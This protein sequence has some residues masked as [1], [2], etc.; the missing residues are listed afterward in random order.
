MTQSGRASLMAFLATAAA[1]AAASVLPV[2]RDTPAILVLPVVV[3]I[4]LSLPAQAGL[5]GI[6]TSVLGLAVFQPA[7]S[8]PI[9]ALR[10]GSFF[11]LGGAI[12][13]LK[14][15]RARALEATAQYRL[16]FELNPLPMW[17][18]DEETLAFQA[19]NHAAI[20]KYGYSRAEFERL[21]LR[22][23]RVE[24][25]IAAVER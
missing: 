13:A 7:A 2:V 14:Y 8:V 15:G 12:V 10:A 20:E 17:V 25:D 21:T 23:I 5:I 11:L 16:L 6:I 19:V 4:G 9:E 18:Y 22:D 24:E 3:L 1:V